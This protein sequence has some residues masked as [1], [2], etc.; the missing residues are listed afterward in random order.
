MKD[1]AKD[2]MLK[3]VGILLICM[4]VGCQAKIG[5]DQEVQID[6][7]EKWVGTYEFSEQSN[8]EDGMF[9]VMDYAIKIYKEDNRYWADLEIIGQTTW[10]N[11]QTEIYGDEEWI[12]F[13]F[14]KELPNN[15]SEMDE[16]VVLFSFR[17]AESEIYTYWGDI[18]PMLYENQHSGRIYF[19]KTH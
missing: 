14:S 13:V 6:T 7:L 4:L 8:A 17:K 5:D 15:M 16:S 2:T 19:S 12:S 11:V 18:Q 9:M 1:C 10:V 3:I